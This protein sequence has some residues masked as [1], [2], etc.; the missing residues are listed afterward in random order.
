M[1]RPYSRHRG[2][3]LVEALIVM[4][5]MSIIAVAAGVALQ[6]LARVPE[7]NDDQLVVS[8]AL[9]DKMEQF[10][11]MTVP[12]LLAAPSGSDTSPVNNLARSWTIVKA[13]PK[14]GS[15]PQ[16][17]FVQITVTCG[18]RSLTSYLTQP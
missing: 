16:N 6:S 10:R 12:A 7:R 1:H 2:L 18:G 8:N 9:V 5:I 13:D 17:D 3:T 15:S 4:T 14:L 11:G